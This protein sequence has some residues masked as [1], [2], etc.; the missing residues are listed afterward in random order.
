MRIPAISDTSGAGLKVIFM[1]AS[2]FREDDRSLYWDLTPCGRTV[3]VRFHVFTRD[4]IAQASPAFCD[5]LATNIGIVRKACR[6]G[7]QMRHTRSALHR[8][9]AGNKRRAKAQPAFKG[10]G[11]AG[12]V[13]KLKAL[14]STAAVGFDHHN[15]T[16]RCRR[17]LTPTVAEKA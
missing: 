2:F 4:T 14:H 3:L 11:F 15:H 13:G 16:R 10:Y 17:S 1:V 8:P 9:R 12:H 7:G 5:I 6:E